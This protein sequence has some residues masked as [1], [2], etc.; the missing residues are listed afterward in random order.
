M[1]RRPKPPG[2]KFIRTSV[3]LPPADW[4]F[5]EKIALEAWFLSGGVVSEWFRGGPRPSISE[6]VRQVV[7]A[8]RVHRAK[9]VKGGGGEWYFY[10][11]G[12]RQEDGRSPVEFRHLVTGEIRRG[13]AH[14]SQE[15]SLPLADAPAGEE[16]KRKRKRTRR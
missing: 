4:Q 10:V 8:A 15:I 2:E 12:P 13:L 11:T 1:G 6:S 3:A 5:L 16:P 7:N 9:V 14:V